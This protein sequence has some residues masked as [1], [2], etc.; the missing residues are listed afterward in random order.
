MKE[1]P[2]K[3][4]HKDFLSEWKHSSE[5]TAEQAIKAIQE[6]AVSVDAVR[7]F[8][9]VI[10]NLSIHPADQYSDAVY[11]GVSKKIE[12]L[13]YHLYRYF[14]LSSNKQISPWD[15]NACIDALEKLFGDSMIGRLLT[16]RE[17][18]HG[19]D[20]LLGELRIE[21]EVVRG[22][23]FPEQTA[24]EIASIQGRHEAWF[25]KKVGIGP[26]RAQSILQAIIRN[27]EKRIVGA[28]P[29][30]RAH[31]AVL[32]ERYQNAKRKIPKVRSGD[33]HRLLQTF[34]KR[35]AAWGFGYVEKLSEI[36]PDVLPVRREQMKDLDPA[37]TFEEWTALVR[38]IGLTNENRKEVGDLNKM[39]QRPLYVLP[40]NT[41]VV[42]DISNAMD[43]LWDRFEKVARQD[44]AF[45]Q[46]AYQKTRAKWLEEKMVSHLSN[47]FTGS[48][49]YRNLTYPDPDKSAGGTT[50]LDAA[51]QWGP[52][53]VLAEAKAR[54]F[55]LHE[56]AFDPGRLRTDI[57]SNVEDAYQQAK[58]AARYI[59]EV[60][61]AEFT[62]K[63][64]GL[65]LIVS[66]EELR[67]IYLVTV[68]QHHL[69]GL[70]TR[71]A[72]LQQLN[73]FAYR[74]F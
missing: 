41:V 2:G 12:I 54:Q 55:R 9:A 70:A 8:V 33:D 57:K 26:S 48:H 14:D 21:A 5:Q 45:F 38:L 28:L 44:D 20:S 64:S 63:H 16:S 40:N 47:I 1:E 65:K 24:E 17:T 56:D 67:R 73:L 29:N 52:F 72:T 10:A 6:L 19:E 60:P 53:L 42:A 15:I 4:I 30:V 7:L 71:L 58:R 61:N 23:A 34:K 27:Q 62:E 49:V 59:R 66:R 50:E 13:A 31:A 37:P 43:V 36:A 39:R 3:T 22:S 18:S 68:S 46:E 69:A 25:A 32:A 74:F 11:G 51:V 35:S